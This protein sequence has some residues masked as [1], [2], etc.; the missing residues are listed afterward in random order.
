MTIASESRGPQDSC[1]QSSDVAARGLQAVLQLCFLPGSLEVRCTV[2]Q[3]AVSDVAG[4]KVG[5]IVILFIKSVDC[6]TNNMDSFS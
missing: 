6:P 5:L 4:P 1:E 2:F 3:H